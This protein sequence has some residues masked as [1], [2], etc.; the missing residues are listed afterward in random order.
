[1]DKSSVPSSTLEGDGLSHDIQPSST[2][3]VGPRERSLEAVARIKVKNRRIRYLNTH[4]GYFSS[5]LELAGGYLI[6]ASYASDPLIRQ[7]SFGL[8]SSY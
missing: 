4:P 6:P 5:S 2:A 3:I 8:R 7:R 1:M